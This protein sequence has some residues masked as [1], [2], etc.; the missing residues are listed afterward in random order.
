MYS[1]SKS[2]RQCIY[3]ATFLKKMLDLL[4]FLLTF[5]NLQIKLFETYKSFQIETLQ[6]C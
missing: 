4:I 2:K 5:Q 1:N 6:V 3:N